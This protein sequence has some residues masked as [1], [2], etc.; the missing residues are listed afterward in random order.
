MA[1][2][3]R[4]PQRPPPD[5]LPQRRCQPGRVRRRR[6]APTA[7]GIPDPVAAGGL[8][9][10]AA[11]GSARAARRRLPV[12]A[13][14]RSAAASVAHHDQDRPGSQAEQ[15]RQRAVRR[16]PSVRR[17]RDGRRRRPTGGADVAP[18]PRRPACRADRAGAAGEL[19]RPVPLERRA[20]RVFDHQRADQRRR[21]R[22]LPAARV[23]G[24]RGERAPDRA[25]AD[26]RRTHRG[27]RRG[28]RAPGGVGVAD[29]H[30]RALRRTAWLGG[31]ATRSWPTWTTYRCRGSRRPATC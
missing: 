7:A 29:R 27:R 19:L 22:R 26:P 31:L 23:Q 1:V 30:R 18:R 14:Y 16:T 4:R 28:G 21:R 13:Q 9:R 3:A 11:H 8:L 20:R 10:Q 6:R 15:A 17:A 12:G 2:P 5:P 25:G 24:V